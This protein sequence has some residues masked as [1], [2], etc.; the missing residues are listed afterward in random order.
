MPKL[1]VTMGPAGKLVGVTPADERALRRLV[2]LTNEL[3]PGNTLGM[4][5]HV[6]RS[7]EFHGRHFAILN[8]IFAAQGVF[9][10]DYNFRKWAEMGAGYCDFVPGRDGVMQAIPK[11]IDYATLDDQEFREV[12]DAVM[13]FL[14]TPYALKTLW[15]AQTD[16]MVSW[17]GVDDLIEA[18]R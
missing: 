15:P 11:S 8:R 12:H 3:K 1:M 6:P 5:Y 18:A 10:D 4:S 14:R 13:T 16:L 2:K 7:P 17:Q 9:T